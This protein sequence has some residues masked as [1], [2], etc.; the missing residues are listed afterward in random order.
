[1]WPIVFC[2]VAALAGICL[3]LV[4]FCWRWHEA[5]GRVPTRFDWPW[6]L[7]GWILLTAGLIWMLSRPSRPRL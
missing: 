5:I 6:F 2:S 7:A 1:M 3:I 4:S